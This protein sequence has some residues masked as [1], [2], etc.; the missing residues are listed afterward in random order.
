MA[1]DGRNKEVVSVLVGPFIGPMVF[2][3]VMLD[4]PA[5]LDLFIKQGFQYA[6]LGSLDYAS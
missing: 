1:P 4:G 2:I 6:F 5:I 3:H